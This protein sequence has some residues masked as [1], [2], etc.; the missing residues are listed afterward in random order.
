[1][2]SILQAHAGGVRHV[3]SPNHTA[4]SEASLATDVDASLSSSPCVLLV[5]LRVGM[6]ALSCTGG[7]LTVGSL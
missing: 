6:R 2:P 4:A 1:M 7:C 5:L 3:Q